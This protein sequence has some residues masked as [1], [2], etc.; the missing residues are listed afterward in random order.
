MAS[1]R[2]QIVAA[3]IVELNTGAPGGIPTAER[4][5]LAELAPTD[6]PSILVFPSSDAPEEIGGGGGA[7][8]RSR[9][10]LVVEC[11]AAGTASIR[12]DQAV[13]PLAVWVVKAL[14]N[15]RLPAGGGQFLN[16]DIVQG[17]TTFSFEEGEAPYCLAAIEMIV[18]YQHLVA[19]PEARV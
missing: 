8:V 1:V 13:D 14:G 9:L 12:P 11:R 6:L 2:D 10:T 17:E 3:A 5:R 18:V 19:D 7:I 15:K 16:H 4:V